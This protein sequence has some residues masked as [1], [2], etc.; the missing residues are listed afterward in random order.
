MGISLTHVSLLLLYGSVIIFAFWLSWKKGYA[1]FRSGHYPET[2]G[3]VIRSAFLNSLVVAI[4]FAAG[5]GFFSVIANIFH[6]KPLETAFLLPP[7]A[8]I[9]GFIVFLPVLIISFISR[10]RW[11][12]L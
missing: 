7:I 9:L 1:R 3:A 2:F 12:E 11:M 10:K 8:F 6:D 4:G 5:T